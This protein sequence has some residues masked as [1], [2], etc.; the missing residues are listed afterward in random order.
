MS[1]TAPRMKTNVMV[2][3][4][5][6]GTR[7][8]CKV[9]SIGAAVFDS[10]GVSDTQQ[11]RAIINRYLQPTALHE[12]IGTLVWWS[13]QSTEAKARIFDTPAQAKPLTVALADFSDWINSLGPDVLVWGNGADFDNPILSAAYYACGLAQP[14]GQW[15]SRCY[16]TLKN[17]RPDIKLVRTGLHHDALDDATSQAAHA[18]SI[19]NAIGGWETAKP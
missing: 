5:T 11:F 12:N 13:T 19:L 3:L 1:N 17:L 7:P 6:L 8:G 4:E 2:D 18:V 15:N 14:W 9:V 16:R 10:A